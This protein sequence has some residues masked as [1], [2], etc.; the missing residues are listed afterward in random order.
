MQLFLALTFLLFGKVFENSSSFPIYTSKKI[1][2]NVKA[3][4][5]FSFLPD[6]MFLIY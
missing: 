3:E 5:S 4:M 6:S 1:Y 2:V